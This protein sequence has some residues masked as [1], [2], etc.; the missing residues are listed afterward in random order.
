[1]RVIVYSVREDEI[2]LFEEM[3]KKY[4]MELK[5]IED[6]LDENSVHLA[7]GYDSL[8]F[9][10]EDI[11][12]K[13]VL[14]TINYFGISYIVSRSTGVDNVDSVTANRLNIRIANVPFYS[15]NSVSEYTILLVLSILR[16]FHLYINRVSIGDFRIKGL[17]GKE[18]RNQTFGIIGTGRIGELT[19]EHLKGLRAKNVLIYDLIEKEKLKQFGVYTSLDDLYSKS[20]VIIYHLPLTSDTKY[21]LCN[22]SINK[23]KDGVIVV[24]VSRGAIINTADLL[25]SLKSGKISAAAIDVYENELPYFRF[26]KRESYIEDNILR[27]LL[28]LPNVIITPHCA[29]YTDESV[30]NMVSTSLENINEFYITNNCQNII[31]Y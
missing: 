3:S 19:I 20:D 7:S 31:K 15:P 14:E 9:L 27:E 5:L 26:D 24:N 1:M 18:I 2:L 21:I 25:A 23:M 30:S 28:S 8:I 11:V 16:N 10:A 13:Y 29:F 4:N 12:N 17:I 6:K 22:D